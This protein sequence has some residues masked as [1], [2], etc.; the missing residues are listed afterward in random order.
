MGMKKL[1]LGFMRLPL[2]N[3]DDYS[4]VDVEKVKKMVDQFMEHG[5][6]YFDTAAP[7]HVGQNEV[8]LREALVKCYPR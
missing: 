4:S 8:A 7:Y 3:T 6:T 1:G 2:R 5:F